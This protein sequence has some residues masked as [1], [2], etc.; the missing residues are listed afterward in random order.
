MAAALVLHAAADA[1]RVAAF[2]GA[3]VL[4]LPCGGGERVDLALAL[5]ALG[6]RGLTSVLVEPGPGLLGALLAE[7]LVDEL[8]WFTA[9]VLIGADGRPALPGRGVEQ[10]EQALRLSAGLSA[11]AVGAEALFVGRV[12][13]SD[14]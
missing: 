8:W 3:G 10:M 13:S 1:D 9:P 14:Q 2:D 12:A 6:A 11:R 5:Q 7:G 4:R